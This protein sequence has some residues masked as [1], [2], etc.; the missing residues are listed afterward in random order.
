VLIDTLE[1]NSASCILE[2]DL[3][4]YEN[5]DWMI[6]AYLE[7]P[8]SYSAIVHTVRK[9]HYIQ[10]E[11]GSLPFVIPQPSSEHIEKGLILHDHDSFL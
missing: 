8:V 9:N 2:S 3:D 6:R 5:G 11:K 7:I 10:S 4:A 1:I